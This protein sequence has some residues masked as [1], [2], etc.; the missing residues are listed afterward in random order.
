MPRVVPARRKHKED[1]TLACE[2]VQVHALQQFEFVLSLERSVARVF[3]RRG[4]VG[5][6]DAGGDAEGDE[7]G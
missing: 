4:R 2:L 6:V 3:G 5:D 7:P 1:V